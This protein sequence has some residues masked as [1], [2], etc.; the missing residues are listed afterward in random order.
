MIIGTLAQLDK[1]NVSEILHTRQKPTTSIENDFLRPESSLVCQTAKVME[2]F[3]LSRI[4][5]S[6]L[7]HMDSKQFAASSQVFLIKYYLYFFS[8][9]PNPFPR[10]LGRFDSLETR[11][12]GPRMFA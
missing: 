5:P 12:K 10:L 2:G 7:D 11:Q 1:V 8:P 6:I 4:L 9:L 3:T